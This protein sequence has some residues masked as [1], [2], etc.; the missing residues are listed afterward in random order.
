MG[1]LKLGGACM[2]LFLAAQVAQAAA[3]DVAVQG[4]EGRAVYFY[5]DGDQVITKLCPNGTYLENQWKSH[6]R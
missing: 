1:W 6:V 5:L 3:P 2:S 4:P